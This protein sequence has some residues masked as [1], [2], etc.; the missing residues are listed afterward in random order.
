MEIEYLCE[1]TVIAKLRSFSRAAEE[2]CI[3]QSSLSKHIL[4]LERELG[5]PLLQ[6][7]SRN[8]TLSAAGEQLLP[9]AA[10]VN[11]LKNKILVTAAKASSREKTLLCIASIPVM[12]QYNITGL[13]AK[14]QR[15]YPLVT[16]E[17]RECEQ[18]E[19]PVLLEN[20]Q[21]EL[22]FSRLKT[23]S[24]DLEYLD[25]CRDNLV[26]VVPKSHPLSVQSAITLEQLRGEKLLSLDSRTGLHDL[27]EDLCRQ[28][29]FTPSVVYTG[30]RP[31]NIVDLAA[32]GMGIALLMKRH[33]D[34]VPNPQVVCID[35]TPTVESTICLVRRKNRPLSSMARAFWSFAAAHREIHS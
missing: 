19:L 32:Q 21:V 31:E 6:R 3:S 23:M 29:G 9:L 10:Q 2:L 26:A 25:F 28:A 15:E 11:E 7:N 18:Q 16:L 22:A 17:I 14:F 8:V 4:A 12:A 30:H 27:C 5:V 34:Y 20:G 13:L 33:T 35:I 1:F 24:E